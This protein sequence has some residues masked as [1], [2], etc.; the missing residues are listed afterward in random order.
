MCCGSKNNKKWVHRMAR[1]R[2]FIELY[3]YNVPIQFGQMESIEDADGTSRAKFVED[4]TLNAARY[5]VT[6]GE[7]MLNSGPNQQEEQFYAVQEFGKVKLNSLAV[8]NGR[9]YTVTEITDG[10]STDPRSFDLLRLVWGN[11]VERGYRGMDV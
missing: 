11:G 5:Q 8:I 7:Q 2:K 10:D 9:Q 6:R 4:Y 3:R 1:L